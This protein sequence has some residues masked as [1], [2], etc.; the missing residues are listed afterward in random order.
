M[1]D[2]LAILEGGVEAHVALWEVSGLVDA[3]FGLPAGGAGNYSPREGTGRS[4]TR[5]SGLSATAARSDP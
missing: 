2:H 5:R 1:A 3:G 4:A